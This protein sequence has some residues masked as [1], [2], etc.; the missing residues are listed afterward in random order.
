MNEIREEETK[1]A[2]QMN[3]SQGQGSSLNDQNSFEQQKKKLVARNMMFSSFPLGG[4]GLRRP[5]TGLQKP[6]GP[7]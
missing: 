5:Q 2:E 6:E 3:T 7:K 4:F 1:D